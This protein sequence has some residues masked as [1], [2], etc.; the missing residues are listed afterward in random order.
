MYIKFKGIVI[1]LKEWILGLDLSIYWVFRKLI[2]FR[3]F[4]F[5]VFVIGL[6]IWELG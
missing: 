5:V 2:D 3:L 4:F 6:F 1:Y